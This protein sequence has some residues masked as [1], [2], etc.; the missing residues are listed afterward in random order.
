MQKTY[1]EILEGVSKKKTKKEKMEE[2]RRHSGPSI[3]TIL[4]YAFDPNVVW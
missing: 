2:L 1:Y 4:G 3:K